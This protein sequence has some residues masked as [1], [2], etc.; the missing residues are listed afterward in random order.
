MQNYQGP[1]ND[2]FNRIWCDNFTFIFVSQLNIK[3]IQNI[4]MYYHLRFASVQIM[5]IWGLVLQLWDTVYGKSWYAVKN[6]TL[7]LIRFCLSTPLPWGKIFWQVTS[8]FPKIDWHKD[9]NEPFV[10][11]CAKDT[12]NQNSMHV[13]KRLVTVFKKFA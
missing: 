13:S 6:E 4:K 5:H 3:H 10:Y 9:L 2:M 8:M 12:Q 11:C 7:H 1:D